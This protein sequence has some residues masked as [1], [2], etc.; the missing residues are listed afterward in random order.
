VA[1]TDTI[2]INAG[3]VSPDEVA[4]S[5]FGGDEYSDE[6]VIDFDERERL[7]KEEELARE[8]ML[9]QGINPDMPN[10]V[11]PEEGGKAGEGAN[12]PQEPPSDGPPAKKEG[13]PFKK[14]K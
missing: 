13:P 14:G 5:R 12:V 4:V 1:E 8:E 6:T 11:S 7:E 9:A 3:V 2:Y 10:V